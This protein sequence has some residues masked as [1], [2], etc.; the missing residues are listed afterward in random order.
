MFDFLTIMPNN[1]KKRCTSSGHKANYIKSLKE[2]CLDLV[3]LS[4][5]VIEID[6]ADLL[7]YCIF[8]ILELEKMSEISENLI[9]VLFLIMLGDQSQF[10]CITEYISEL[11][12]NK[13]RIHLF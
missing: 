1:L 9:Q 11:I 7:H 5:K 8:I 4:F 6:K 2:K 12:L 13:V 3:D 10:N